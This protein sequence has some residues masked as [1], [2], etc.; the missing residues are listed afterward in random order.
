MSEVIDI[1]DGDGQATSRAVV[2][3]ANVLKDGGLVVVPDEAGYQLLASITSPEAVGLL[4]A[5]SDASP[6]MTPIVIGATADAL[7]PASLPP[8]PLALRLTRR[9]WPGPVV[10]DL[11][12]G[13]TPPRNWETV[14]WNW[15]T[16]E[17]R[18]PLRVPVHEVPRSLLAEL[19]GV[20][21]GC[22]HPMTATGDPDTEQAS[23]AAL[24]LNA[25]PPRFEG[26]DTWIRV[27]A[28]SWEVTRTGVVGQAT[29]MRLAS[30]VIVFVC[31]GNTCRSPMAEALFRKLLVQRLQCRDGELIE[32]G[33]LVA[34]AGVAAYGGS[35]VSPGAAQS[36]R[37]RGVDF[38]SHVSQPLTGDLAAQA[39]HL[40]T[41]TRGH[42]ESV[43]RLWPETASRIQLLDADG[44]DIED[45][46]GGS[47]EVYTACCNAIEE[48]LDR[49]LTEVM[50]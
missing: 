32:R 25:G 5:A 8:N 44:G 13:N 26:G 15:V 28:D 47:N 9:C 46:I 43:L 33:F 40:V 29:V 45:P 20:L 49:L 16:R 30:C 14:W 27:R 37:E 48:N 3:A 24:I 42:R 2:R 4:L 6:A 31:T 21:L 35:P 18:L 36:L 38:S 19:D 10:I 34:S 23:P 7:L 22:T 41:M 17:Q 11:D 12:P 50:N 1:H 39:D